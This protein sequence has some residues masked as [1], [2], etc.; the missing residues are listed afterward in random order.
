MGIEVIIDL[1]PLN[2]L[3]RDIHG[4]KGKIKTA[5]KT[6]RDLYV[7]VMRSRFIRYS[8]GGGSWPKLKKP[9]A[10]GRFPGAILKDTRT[11]AKALTI[12]RRNF[13]GQVTIVEDLEFGIVVGFGRGNHP[14]GLRPSMVDLTA[15]HHF[16]LGRLPVRELLVEPNEETKS[17]MAVVMQ[18]AIGE[19][20][21]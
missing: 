5:F 19:Q 12:K 15:Y 1:G 14:G 4:K 20:Y 13:R 2:G 18:N 8:A 6:W 3:E 7:R 21:K 10:S 11:I 17:K 16:G 9:R